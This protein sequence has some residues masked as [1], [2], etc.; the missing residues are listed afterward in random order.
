MYLYMSSTLP[1]RS[2]LSL[3]NV[4][5]KQGCSEMSTVFSPVSVGSE[6]DPGEVI[7]QLTPE[8]T[9]PVPTRRDN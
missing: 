8:Q 4:S 9:N 6:D 2:S 7:G 1:D 3:E 5:Y